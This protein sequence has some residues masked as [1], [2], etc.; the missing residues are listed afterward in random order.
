ME[1]ATTPLT[2]RWLREFYFICARA[3][4][5]K[6]RHADSDATSNAH[7][8]PHW[9]I[10]RTQL[11]QN[12]QMQKYSLLSMLEMGAGTLS[13][14]NKAATLLLLTLLL[15]FSLVKTSVWG[16]FSQRR[17]PEENDK[18]FNFDMI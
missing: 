4:V 11:C 10:D 18:C 7:G 2:R 14:Q 8:Q 1:E 13:L 3:A 17:I 5:F 9:T 6:V 15:S 12:S 16:V